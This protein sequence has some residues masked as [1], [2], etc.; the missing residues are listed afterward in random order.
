M[1]KILISLLCVL[2]LCGCTFKEKVQEQTDNETSTM[3]S[4]DNSYYKIVSFKGSELR[5]NFYLSYGTSQDFL[6]IGRGL[7]Q[8]S[9]SHFSTSSYYMSE[10]QYLG[11][12]ELNELLKR[13]KDK[14]VYPYTLQPAKGTSIEGVFEPIMV[15]SVQEQDYYIKDGKNYV[16]K[17]VSFAI[18]LNPLTASGDTIE[19]ALS[20]E[21]VKKYGKQCIEKFY[22]F[23]KEY[24]TF[25]KIKNLPILITVYQAT[26]RSSSTIDGRYILKALC[27]KKVG[28]IENVNYKTVYFTGK[29]AEELDS[30][31]HSEFEIIKSKLKNA[32]YEAAGF[33]ATARYINNEIQS[34]VINANLNTKTYTELIYLTDYIASL[35]ED[36]FTYDFDIKVVVNSQDETQAIIIKEKGQDVK[37]SL[38][39]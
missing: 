22:K 3:Q 2:L 26:D 13:E 10:G 19:P 39:Y 36:G 16:L 38:L 31:T 4:F 5:E 24:D 37:S 27:E 1:K 33:Q 11:L 6:S 23:I 17:G 20:D 18:V 21:T 14:S 28:N 35:I 29:D 34:M 7:Q 15:S 32:A 9:S 12:G 25:K 30:V 8:L